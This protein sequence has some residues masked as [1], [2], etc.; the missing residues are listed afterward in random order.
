MSTL[1]ETSGPTSSASIQSQYLGM[2][3]VQL[4]HQDPLEP[5]KSSEMTNQLTLLAQLSQLEGMRGEFSK[6]GTNFESMREDF[7]S[8]LE[9]TQIMHGTRLIGRE[10][11]FSVDTPPPFPR[12]GQTGWRGNIAPKDVDYT[13]EVTGTDLGEEGVRLVVGDVTVTDRTGRYAPRVVTINVPVD[14][15]KVKSIK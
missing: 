7:A 10:I 5:M 13:A 14:I 15:N 1:S 11:S 6:M 8:V 12:E 9:A 3:I 2:L 4:Q